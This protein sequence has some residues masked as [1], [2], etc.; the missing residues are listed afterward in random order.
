MGSVMTPFFWS[1]LQH[2]QLADGRKVRFSARSSRC[3]RDVESHQSMLRLRYPLWV[4]ASSARA[5]KT[6][7]GASWRM[8]WA[9]Q[10]RL[11]DAEPLAG[12]Y[13]RRSFTL[14]FH[15]TLAPSLEKF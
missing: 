11:S 5:S 14:P 3:G 10:G 13:A 15:W 6:E 1:P 2:E 7:S 12:R 9:K 4:F 8:E